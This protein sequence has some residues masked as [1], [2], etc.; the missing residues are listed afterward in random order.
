MAH[1]R[2]NRDAQGGPV[3][4]GKSEKEDEQAVIGPPTTATPRQ[5]DP[6]V[7]I[8]AQRVPDERSG[9]FAIH[10]RAIAKV[11]TDDGDVDEETL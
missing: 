1:A 5:V 6:V 3:G 8:L 7:R 4:A 2:T 9:S 10:S 11:S